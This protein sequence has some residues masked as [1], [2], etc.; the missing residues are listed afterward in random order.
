MSLIRGTNEK[1]VFQKKFSNV[2]LVLSKKKIVFKCV[3]RDRKIKNKDIK[4]F[5]K[6][7]RK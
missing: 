1:N 6:N 4:I 3:K 5:L 7:H 2:L